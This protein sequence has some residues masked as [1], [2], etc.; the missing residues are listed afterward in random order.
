MTIGSRIKE[1]RSVKKL[2]QLELAKSIG[3]TKAAI[4]NY[5]NDVSVPKPEIF[6]KIMQALEVTADYLYQDM[7]AGITDGFAIS[8]DEKQIV[9]NCRKLAPA[10]IKAIMQIIKSL[11]EKNPEE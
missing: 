1:A 6:Q 5:E 3:V 8:N 4:S 9:L 2:T 10:T 11:A 7:A